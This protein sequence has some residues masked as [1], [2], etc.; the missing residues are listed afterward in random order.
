MP[1]ARH[2]R[3]AWVA[4]VCL[5]SGCASMTTAEKAYIGAVGADLGTTAIGLSRGLEEQNPIF[6]GGTDGETLAR[7][8]VLNAA[9]YW[10][11]HKWINRH[12][13]AM[14]TKYWRIVFMFRA[15]VVGWNVYQI[16]GAD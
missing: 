14:Q 13:D 6:R 16:A 7:A 3:A 10:A 2:L 15:P 9:V 5:L 4:G 11:M 8:V 1:P 12:T